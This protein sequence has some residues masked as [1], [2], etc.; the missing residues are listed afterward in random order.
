MNIERELYP[1]IK[2]KP[3]AQSQYVECVYIGGNKIAIRGMTMHG[4][5]WTR[6]YGR[7]SSKNLGANGR[8][9]QLFQ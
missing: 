4:T 5:N 8:Q 6:A 1:N 7:R 3:A 2:S 9:E